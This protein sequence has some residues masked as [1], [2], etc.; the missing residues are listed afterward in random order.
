MPGSGIPIFP[1]DGG[2]FILPA[3][4]ETLTAPTQYRTAPDPKLTGM[5]PG[6]P[7]IVGNEAAERFSFYG[8]NSILVIFMTTY[9]M[10]RTGRLAVMSNEV[11]T[12][13]AHMFKFAV[14]F[15]PIGGA[16]LADSIWGKYRTILW[17]SMVYCLG[18]FALAMDTTR[19]G[20][21]VGLGLIAL[22]AGGIKPCVSANV[23]DQ[24]GRGNQHLLAKAFG[25]FYFSINLGSAVSIYLCPELLASPNFGPHWAFGIPGVLMVV[26]TII[27]WMGRKRFV[28]IPP[29]GS[30]FMRTL[31]SREGALLLGRIGMVYLVIIIFWALWDQ[32][33]GIEWTLQATKM[34]LHF[35]GREWLPAQVQVVNG[36]Y[37]LA[38]IPLFNY[39]IYPMI[40]RFFPLTP[41]RKISIGLFL[42]VLSFVVIWRIEL[43]IEAG[44]KPNV[45]WQL[46]AYAILTA[47]EVMVSITG[48]EFSYAQA[49]NRLKSVV[50][51]LWL[52]TIAFGNFLAGG[53]AFLIPRLKEMGLNLEGSGY[54]R[55]YTLL[56]LGAAVLFVIIASFYQ[57]KTHLQSDEPAAE[58]VGL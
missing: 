22:G 37:V 19:L 58:G 25:W 51:A 38:F 27:F 14:Y 2:M 10:D 42:T 17:L 7:Y 54:F 49:P 46:L 47:G 52:L 4:A 34:D 24:F 56:M 21:A 8:M 39:V 45:I 40:G 50:M 23:G 44:G 43:A 3:M 16:I 33:N 26:A 57:G 28:H 55:F 53:I 11:A 13:W 20:L 31:F 12:G 5:P 41:L 29:G 36:L 9:L 48:L 30:E 18:H 35:L 6:I 32:S 15:L 1:L